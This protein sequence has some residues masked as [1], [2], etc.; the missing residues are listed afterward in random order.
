MVNT[1]EFTGRAIIPEL[2]VGAEKLKGPI[3]GEYARSTAELFLDALN[4]SVRD[5][6]GPGK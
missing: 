6:S 4:K 1:N 3:T 5:R 2:M